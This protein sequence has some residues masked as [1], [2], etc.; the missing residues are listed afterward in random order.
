M[1][2]S[3]AVRVLLMMCHGATFDDACAWVLRRFPSSLKRFYRAEISAKL[4]T[5]CL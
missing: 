3:L 5:A 1:L 2:K 4:E